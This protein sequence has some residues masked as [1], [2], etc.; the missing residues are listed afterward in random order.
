MTSSCGL[1]SR[2][3]GIAAPSVRR[4]NALWRRV[5]IL[6]MV[7]IVSSG[8]GNPLSPLADPQ[9]PKD[10]G[11]VVVQVRDQADLPV[12]SAYACVEMPEAA[13]RVLGS[14]GGIESRGGRREGCVGDRRFP[15]YTQLNERRSN[16]FG[17]KH[18]L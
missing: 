11:T 14:T 4:R 9:L 16:Q 8:C 5:G 15:A 3:G 12:A 7:P 1:I 13:S 2:G 18:V 10:P 6:A 17:H